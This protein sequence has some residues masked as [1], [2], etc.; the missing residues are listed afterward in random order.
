MGEKAK[1]WPPKVV[2]TFQIA[3]L[4]AV[5]YYTALWG[6][7]AGTVNTFAALVWAPTGIALA[8]L[9]IE[10]VKIWPGVTLAAFFV[11]YHLG[12]SPLTAAGMAAG[13]TLEAV[14]ATQ[15]LNYFGFDRGMQR[16]RDVISLVVLGGLFSTLISAF[17]G[18]GSLYLS[19]RIPAQE[20]PIT[21]TAWWFGDM[22]GAFLVTPFLLV[23]SRKPVFSK[24][25]LSTALKIVALLTLTT[26]ASL[27]LFSYTPP[28]DR[29]VLFHPYL[30][31]PM[32]VIIALNLD[33]KWMV[34]GILVIAATAIAN[35][36][37]G[38]GPFWNGNVSE[39]LLQAQIFM[40]ILAVSKMILA[41]AATERRVQFQAT[42]DA[43]RGRD[44]F[45]SIASHE[46]KTPLTSLSLRLQLT[47]I[48]FER[49]NAAI[50]RLALDHIQACMGQLKR[51]TAL[52]DDLLDLTRIRAG[53]MQ[54]TKEPVDL[55]RVVHNVTERLRMEM[56]DVK[57]P[58]RVDAM[59]PAVGLWDQVRI[60]QV[61]NNLLS[62]ALKYGNRKPVAI[63]VAADNSKIRMQVKDQGD[64]V[65]PDMRERI[66]ERFERGGTG[67]KISGLGLGL[68]ICRQ[69]VDA[70][71][72]DIWVESDNG[73]G[74][75]F[76]VELPVN[77]PNA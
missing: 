49:S 76:T 45:L 14:V 40:G 65:S 31:F 15:L 53:R 41:A 44:E 51:L 72:G 5:Y 24:V 21:W 70:H 35:T 52:I 69:I 43:L 56:T 33:Q 60:E 77:S 34:T 58:I 47:A 10:G 13:N 64:G 57:I 68:Y 50:P 6:F 61:V 62:N 3:I 26:G 48:E 2:L 39:S 9:L 38:R 1:F 27:F 29:Q 19:G 42:K 73:K 75:T 11:N 22:L 16:L 23:W 12:A 66:F 67:N 28:A 18:V 55:T 59:E 74:S 4:A 17:L 25:P 71:G 63:H 36:L 20:F 30:V 54:L 8:A 37:M 7:H 46:L 32:L